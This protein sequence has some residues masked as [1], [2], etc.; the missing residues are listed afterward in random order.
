MRTHP[1][2][3]AEDKAA[4][5]IVKTKTIPAAIASLS[6]IPSMHDAYTLRWHQE[7]GASTIAEVAP[8]PSQTIL[9]QH[10]ANYELWHTEDRARS[11]FAS[12]A[13][14]AEVKRLI[15]RTN[16]RRN[17]LTEQIDTLLLAELAPLGL[18]DHQAELHSESPGLMIDRLSIL[19]LKL[20]HTRE[21]LA[22][23]GASSNAPAGHA[24]RNQARLA[25]LN[26][27]RDDLAS[28]LNRLWSLVL[29]GER[30]FKLYRQLKMYNDPAL[31]PVIYNRLT[32]K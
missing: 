32:E 26:E 11:P 25:V 1:C 29:T 7:E 8:E 31:N 30:R 9:A 2:R 28:C 4:L 14:V 10:R 22:R 6:A 15:D 5:P 13:E 19:A 17:D 16:Q 21:E 27:Q 3:A 20:F 24:E 18:P 12:Q 23:A